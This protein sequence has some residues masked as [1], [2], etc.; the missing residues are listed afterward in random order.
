[1]SLFGQVEHAV[2]MSSSLIRRLRSV[3]RR[4]KLEGHQGSVQVCCPFKKLASTP[5]R[6][7]E[8]EVERKRKSERER[9]R[10]GAKKKA[11]DREIH[12]DPFPMSTFEEKLVP[13]AMS[14]SY[15]I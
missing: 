7:G 9:E 3:A 6:E 5:E 1:M 15:E 10:G 14:T 11:I 4:R 12:F 13:F 8:R 2:D